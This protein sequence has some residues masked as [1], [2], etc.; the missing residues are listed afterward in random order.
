M[1]GCSSDEALRYFLFAGVQFF[2]GGPHGQKSTKIH[3]NPTKMFLNYL[4]SL[5]GKEG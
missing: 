4:L 3:K 2:C 5:L 1:A